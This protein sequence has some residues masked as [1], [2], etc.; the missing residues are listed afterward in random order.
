MIDRSFALHFKGISERQGILKSCICCFVHCSNY[1]LILVSN[2][3]SLNTMFIIS[4][5][6][7][8]HCFQ[9][10]V[11]TL[12]DKS[13]EFVLYCLKKDPTLLLEDGSSHNYHSINLRSKNHKASGRA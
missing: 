6:N 8:S 11:L 9:D 4:C 1:I 5:R 7:V 2:L 13:L 3:L 12:C 10:S